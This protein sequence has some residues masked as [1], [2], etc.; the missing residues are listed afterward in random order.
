MK[1]DP[2][3]SK[4]LRQVQKE[5]ID[6]LENWSKKTEKVAGVPILQ[7]FVY[8]ILQILNNVYLQRII[9]EEEKE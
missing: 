9:A 6:L 2:L 4:S 5:H 3:S 1:K 7:C 8:D